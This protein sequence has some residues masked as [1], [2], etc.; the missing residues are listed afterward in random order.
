METNHIAYTYALLANLVFAFSVQIFTHY[1]RKVSA[2]WMN[3]VKAS[4]ALVLF[5]VTIVIMN[6]NF[7]F[8]PNVIL[9]LICSGLLGLG[10]GDLALL[11]ALRDLGPGRAM[12][13]VAFH[14]IITGILSYF[15]FDQSLSVNK[16]LAIV[17][18]I[19]CI[20]VYS[21]ESVKKEGNWG[22]KGIA[23]V[24]VAIVLD[25]IGI[26]ML[27]EAKELSG[28]NPFEASFY[29]CLGAVSFFVVWSFFKPIDVW[30]GFKEQ[31]S[32]SILII[33]AGSFLG[34]FLALAFIFKA[35]TSSDSLATIAS[36][37]ISCS[38]FAAL[39]ECIH[40]KKLPGR[41]LVFSFFFMIAGVCTFIFVD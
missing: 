14:P 40:Q 36:L 15:T 33:F 38:I 19:L 25:S 23:L 28:I 22:G 10:I 29:R 31:S 39:F 13:L 35:Y 24:L 6:W 32:K 34:T 26:M 2:I 30:K 20:L 17:F 3:F 9:L 27:N 21:L 11:T 16:M 37:N 12:M 5:T 18:M 8:S 4:I 7:S 41:Y 1:S